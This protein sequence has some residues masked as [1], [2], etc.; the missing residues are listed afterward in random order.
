MALKPLDGAKILALTLLMCT[1]SG[2]LAARKLV[3][4]DPA[5]LYS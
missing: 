4:V 5:E 3:V 1:L 2:L